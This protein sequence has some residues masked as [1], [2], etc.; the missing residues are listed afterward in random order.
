M[1]T[2]LFLE[3]LDGNVSLDFRW[4]QRDTGSLDE[5][6]VQAALD[7]MTELEAGAIANPDE[8]RM[9]G[10]YWLR[11]PELAPKPEFQAEITTVEEYIQLLV[12]K[13]DGQFN[14]V[15]H[16]G[17]GGS[18]LGPQ[19]VDRALS[20][21]WDPRQLHFIDNTDPDGAARVLERV[22]LDEALVV[23]V[24]KSG[25]TA[26]TRNGLALV[27]EALEAQG[28]SL[29]ERA[30]AI[31]GGGSILWKRAEEEGWIATVPMWDWVGGRTSVTSAVGLVP[32]LLAG[33]DAEAF[34]S[35]A[36]AMDA[37]TRGRDNNPA[38]VLAMT[39]WIQAKE[40]KRPTM[41]TLPYNDRLSLLAQYLQQLVMESLG[42]AGDGL[43]VY[44]NKGS[45]DQHAYVQQLRDGRPDFFAAFIEVLDN[46]GSQLEVQAGATAGDF[47]SGFLAG[48]RKALSEAGRDSVTISI[49]RVDEYHLG[50]IV[51]LFE[52]AVGFYATFIGINAY[53][54]PGVEAGKKA[55]GAI[56]ELQKR[57]L[58]HL[59]EGGK[60]T[61]EALAPA[62]KADPRDVFHVLRRLAVN[63]LVACQ[64]EG[65][66]RVFSKA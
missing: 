13:L 26:E 31:T 4:A 2:P 45:T 34:L 36:A 62:L 14:H 44:G 27:A 48:T 60:G 24:S 59:A 37:A 30:I 16:V 58:A 1:E 33:Q 41:V 3:V 49:A 43:A 53:H 9:V 54:Q 29:P 39:W 51:A 66:E 11:A 56:L 47:L 65:L 61:A 35:G 21:P 40:R 6:Q 8:G 32:M 5:A 17:I 20:S 25:G 23:V 10:H 38:L 64:G 28:L 15:I 12:D 57:A 42:K 18:A 50:A 63:G 19:L 52:R 7:A 55:A 22:P 46:R